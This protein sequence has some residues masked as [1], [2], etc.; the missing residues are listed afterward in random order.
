MCDQPLAEAYRDFWK[1]R[2]SAMGILSDDRALRAMAED[3]DDLRTHPRLRKP[4]AE[5]LEELER[6][7]RTCP[8]R[9]EQKELLKEAYRSAL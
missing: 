4:R 7:I 5:K 3:L 2:A 8:L 1:G 6:R 9:E